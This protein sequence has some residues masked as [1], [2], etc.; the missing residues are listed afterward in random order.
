LPNDFDNSS[1]GKLMGLATK[2]EAYAAEKSA[3]KKRK[4][5]LEHQT[6][7]MPI[8]DNP[9]HEAYAQAFFAGLSNGGT[10]EKAYRAAGYL[11]TNKNSANACASRLML[12][13]A[14]RV[15][16]LQAEAN[17]RIQPQID[18][19]RERVGCRLDLASRIAEEQK[20]PSAIASSELGI[21]KVFGHI[22]EDIDH[23]KQSFAQAKSM[24]EIGKRLLQS[25]GLASPDDASVAEAIEAN[26]QFVA[27]LEEI[28]DKAEARLSASCGCGACA[29]ER[30]QN[31]PDLHMRHRISRQSLV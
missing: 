27:R 19:S 21:A 20:N 16:E 7:S 8:L 14:N 18:L 13:I 23:S 24:K 12:R 10:Q 28:R 15:R 4:T 11:V 26:D 5:T 25:V 1:A 9:R 2:S 3:I 31:R 6:Q 29:V 22:G 17:A 30:V